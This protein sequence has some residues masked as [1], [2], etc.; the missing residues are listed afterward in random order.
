MH[1]RVAR[2]WNGL[3]L[4]LILVGRAWSAQSVEHVTLDLGVVS[5][6]ATIGCRDYLTK[7]VY[8]KKEKK[9]LIFG[10]Q[11]LVISSVYSGVV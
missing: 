1:P 5:S 9:N 11:L 10:L 6:S 4:E 7:N 2:L 3:N 8:K